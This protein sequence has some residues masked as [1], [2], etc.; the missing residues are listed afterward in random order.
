MMEMFCSQIVTDW[1]GDRSSPFARHDQASNTVLSFDQLM[2][3]CLPALDSLAGERH[4]VPFFIQIQISDFSMSMYS[5]NINKFHDIMY[6]NHKLRVCLLYSICEQLS[7]DPWKLIRIE[8]WIFIIRKSI[9]FVIDRYAILR[10]LGMYD[11]F[12]CFFT[13]QLFSV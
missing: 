1:L 4:C 13:L 10:H 6:Y 12:S 7:Q 8:Y 9:Y 3:L 5:L 2:C 11:V